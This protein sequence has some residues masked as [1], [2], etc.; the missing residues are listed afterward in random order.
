M[1]AGYF[2]ANNIQAGSQE[3]HQMN[4]PAK[5][6][7]EMPPELSNAIPN[8]VK[9]KLKVPAYLP[10][11]VEKVHGQV[12]VRVKD[13][14]QLKESAEKNESA[15]NSID[16]TQL[17]ED[18]LAIEQF[19]YGNNIHMYLLVEPGGIDVEYANESDVQQLTLS[20]GST[21]AYIDYGFS[22]MINWLDEET[23]YHYSMDV[24]HENE[25]QNNRLTEEDLVKMVES[26]EV[27][28]Y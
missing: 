22:Q 16:T 9:S 13:A 11:K 14:N 6:F 18:E 4:Q 12:E 8:S 15:S 23:G 25:E 28:K 3:N 19:F 26:L 7:S 27:P 1:T 20:D 2:I 17:A 24:I 10:F 5:S 21:A